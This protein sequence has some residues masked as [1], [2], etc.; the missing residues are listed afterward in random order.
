ML[1]QAKLERLAKRRVKLL[2]SFA[3]KAAE[4]PEHI[5]WF[6]N[7]EQNAQFQTRSFKPPYETVQARTQKLHKTPV[8]YFTN[9]LN[10]EAAKTIVP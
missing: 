5:S 3:K 9:L 10:A 2:L 4:H 7:Q 8:S 6:L 1:A